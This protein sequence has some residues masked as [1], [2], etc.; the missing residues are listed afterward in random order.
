MSQSTLLSRRKTLKMLAGI[1]MLPLGAGASAAL[2]TACGGGSDGGSVAFK[3]VSFSSMAAPTLAT[4]AAMATTTVGSAMKVTFA[5][6]S[7]QSY[8]LAYQPFF[9]TGD[10]VSDGKGGTIL[11]GGLLMTASSVAA[12]LLSTGAV[13]PVGIVTSLVGVPFLFLL[14][15]RETGGA[16]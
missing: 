10:K 13:L 3:S 11:A 14:L 16:R 5:D 1:P 7:T 4:P 2:L 9:I 15:L 6:D 8:N 12:K